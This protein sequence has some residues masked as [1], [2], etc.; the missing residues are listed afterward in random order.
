M[1]HRASV[2]SGMAYARLLGL[3]PGDRTTVVFSLTYI[4]AMHAH[5]LPALLSGAELVLLDAP[6]PRRL[7]QVLHE[8]Q[9]AWAY[10]VPS[11][12][13]LCLRVPEFTAAALP[14]LR[15]LASGGASFPPSLVADL[16]E[17]L[18]GTRLLDVY[19]LTET[20]SPAC[21]LRDLEFAAHPGSVGRPLDCMEAQVRDARGRVL[22]AGTA[23]DLHLRGSLVTTGYVG[24]ADATA[25]AL[26]ADGWFST[27][28]VA[29]V[30]DGGF[31]SIVDRR[32]DMINRGGT[33]VFPAEVERVLREHPAVE[34]AA[35]VGVPDDLGGESVAAVVVAT[36]GREVAPAELRGWVRD[37]LAEHAAPRLVELSEDLPRNRVGKVD[38]PLLR[39]RLA[40]GGAGR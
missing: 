22:P 12:W 40:G 23:G 38:K 6:S 36:P 3:V 19:G 8:A 14:R 39:E 24:D 1:V 29:Q 31:V 15:H 18:P 5:V 33:K 4:S 16:R 20:H 17:R 10:A 11:V 30:D 9:V 34:D 7:V 37:H 13:R 32:K 35:V 28:D 21:V 25:A 26:D 27:G 2:H